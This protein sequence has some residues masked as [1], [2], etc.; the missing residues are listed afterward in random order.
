VAYGVRGALRGECDS[1]IV[2]AMSGSMTQPTISDVFS[3]DGRTLLYRQV[4][5]SG[6]FPKRVYQT[7]LQAMAVL[8]NKRNQTQWHIV[9]TDNGWFAVV[10]KG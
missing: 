8:A 5:T 10:R 2:A 6:Q 3:P 7:Q 4:S 9:Q 1:G